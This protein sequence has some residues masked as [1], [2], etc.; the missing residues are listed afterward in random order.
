VRSSTAP[1]PAGGRSRTACRRAPGPARSPRARRRVRQ[2]PVRLRPRRGRTPPQAATQRVPCLRYVPAAT[3]ASAMN[4]PRC[5]AAQN[6][7]TTSG[8]CAL[9]NRAIYSLPTSH[10]G[11][12]NGP[13]TA[14]PAPPAHASIAA[15]ARPPGSPPRRPMRSSSAAPDASSASAPTAACCD[16]RENPRIRLRDAVPAVSRMR[17]SPAVPVRRSFGT[18][19]ERAARARADDRNGRRKRPPKLEHLLIVLSVAQRTP[20]PAGRPSRHARR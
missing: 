4:S 16:H 20:P 15:P 11:Q 19:R 3:A 14:T 2:R 10:A 12:D 8:T 6:G 5:S 1:G 9:T 17:A 13:R 7:C 18:T